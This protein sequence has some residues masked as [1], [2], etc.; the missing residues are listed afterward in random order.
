[1][2]KIP[3]LFLILTFLFA[4]AA[5]KDDAAVTDVTET[6]EITTLAPASEIPS[7][8]T[9]PTMTEPAATETTAPAVSEAVSETTTAAPVTEAP[10]TDAPV[11]EAPVTEAPVTEAPTTQVPPADT[12]KEGILKTLSDAV[13]KTKAFTDNITVSHTESFNIVEPVVKLDSAEMLGTLATRAVNF[14]KDLVLKPSSET[15][16]FSGG[17]ATTSEG[18]TTQLLLP[19]DKAFALTPDAV[20][21]AEL[22]EENGMKHVKLTLVPEETHSLA[23]VPVNHAN[24]IGYLDLD[25]SFKIIQI[26]EIDIK[27]PGS[28]ID[29]MIRADGYVDSVT[30]T[31][32]LEAF[33]KAHGMGISGSATFS[34]SQSEIWKINW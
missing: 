11:T 31:I 32:N 5:C 4:F 27:Y 16:S 2:K 12:S 13:N 1:M 25:G 3:S 20:A 10:T 9:A 34:G 18:E 15:Y 29:A 26:D 8:A 33:S 19:K 30:Y 21:N 17:K 22:T 28:V 24:S 7:E 23:E 6:T 14:V